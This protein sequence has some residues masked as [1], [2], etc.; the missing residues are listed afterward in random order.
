MLEGKLRSKIAE[1][2]KREQKIMTLEQELAT[3]ITEVSREVLLKDQEIESLRRRHKEDKNGVV[4]D[5]AAVEVELA[6]TRAENARLKVE[7]E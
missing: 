3:K 6:K 7:V 5:K 4:K 2:G 1:L